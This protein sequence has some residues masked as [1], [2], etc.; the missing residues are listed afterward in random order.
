MPQ[1]FNNREKYTNRSSNLLML[2]DNVSEEGER[3]IERETERESEGVGRK[4]LKTY[5]CV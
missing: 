2:K 5:G 3:E 1:Q 4:T